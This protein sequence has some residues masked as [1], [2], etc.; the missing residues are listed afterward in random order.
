MLQAARADAIRS[1]LVF[2]HLLEGDPEAVGELLLAHSEH[3]PAHPDPAPYVF[4]DGV[5]QSFDHCLFH[6][7]SEVTHARVRQPAIVGDGPPLETDRIGMQ[8]KQTTSATTAAGSASI[9]SPLGLLDGLVGS[10]LLLASLAFS[11]VLA[12]R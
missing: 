11:P 7:S 4:V 12:V 10:S 1:V 9:V 5:S 2:L 3:L 8:R 6:G